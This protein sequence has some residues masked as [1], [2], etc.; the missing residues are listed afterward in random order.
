MLDVHHPNR[1][2]IHNVLANAS[3]TQR[4]KSWTIWIRYRQCRSILPLRVIDLS[5]RF[6]T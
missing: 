1:K 5:A 4:Y 3:G 6:D 2:M